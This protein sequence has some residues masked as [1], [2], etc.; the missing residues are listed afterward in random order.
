MTAVSEKVYLELNDAGHSAVTISNTDV[1][2]GAISWLKRFV[3]GDTRYSPF[4]CP[5]PAASQDRHG[6]AVSEH[7]RGLTGK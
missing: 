7:L 5:G 2:T 1:A 3:D 4:I 6:V